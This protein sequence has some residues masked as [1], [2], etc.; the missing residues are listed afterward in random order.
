MYISCNPRFHTAVGP[1]YW[2]ISSSW[3]I[4]VTRDTLRSMKAEE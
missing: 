4:T 1:I 2:K 3:C